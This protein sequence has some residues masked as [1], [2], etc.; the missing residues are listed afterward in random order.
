MP[1]TLKFMALAVWLMQMNTNTLAILVATILHFVILH[2]LVWSPYNTTMLHDDNLQ[3]RL[4]SG[5]KFWPQPPPWDSGLSL[6][7]LPWARICPFITELGCHSY[8]DV[9]VV[10]DQARLFVHYWWASLWINHQNNSHQLWHTAESAE[11]ANQTERVYMSSRSCVSKM[12]CP[13]VKKFSLHVNCGRDSV[14]LS[15][16]KQEH[17]Y[18]SSCIIRMLF[19]DC[20]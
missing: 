4:A 2:W 6:K 1:A 11:L 5:P 9:L 12:T 10:R 17:L 13:Y 3:L 19:K 20:Y 15:Q 18:S 14:L 16:V 8:G 7:T